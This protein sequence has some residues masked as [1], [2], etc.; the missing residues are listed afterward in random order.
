[1][2][3]WLLAFLQGIVNA[4][5]DHI[6]AAERAR[7]DEMELKILRELLEELKKLIAP[8]AKPAS[9]KAAEISEAAIKQV[10]TL[11]KG[12]AI[13]LATYA[14]DNIADYIEDKS[15]S[16]VAAVEASTR[17]YEALTVLLSVIQSQRQWLNEHLPPPSRFGWLD[18][19]PRRFVRPLYLAMQAVE[20]AATLGSVRLEA[21]RAQ[22]DL[23]RQ[24]QLASYALRDVWSALAPATTQSVPA[25]TA[26]APAP[27]PPSAITPT[28]PP[29][30]P[31]S[32]PPAPPVAPVALQPR[33]SLSPRHKQQLKDA[34]EDIDKLKKLYDATLQFVEEFAG[35]AKK[36]LED[37]TRPGG[38]IS[39][40]IVRAQLALVVSFC[41]HSRLVV[42][43]L[44]AAIIEADKN[45]ID[46]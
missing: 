35:Q 27:T 36:R 22:R 2:G 19:R 14:Q 32:A 23:A 6:A 40:I 45:I 11:M 13:T 31:A 8:I 44:H 39:A 7:H 42:D 41:V 10:M 30:A 38:G 43:G 26:L 18:H 25:Q 17:L 37:H 21:E 34:S 4:I 1:M 28:P 20:L 16:S 33:E 29:A 9:T 5:N 3:W 12:T 24:H 15:Q 46:I